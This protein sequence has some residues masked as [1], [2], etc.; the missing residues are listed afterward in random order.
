M[1][2]TLPMRGGCILHDLPETDRQRLLDELDCHEA[3]FFRYA[4]SDGDARF[5]NRQRQDQRSA[6][7]QRLPCPHPHG[8]GD[9]PHAGVCPA[10][11]A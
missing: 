2:L 10:R 4:W 1:T 9:Q 5:A 6:L 11:N 3:G 8:A 7:L